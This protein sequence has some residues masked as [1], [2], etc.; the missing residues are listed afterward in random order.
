MAASYYQRKLVE[1]PADGD[2]PGLFEWLTMHCTK[3]RIGNG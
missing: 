3:E 2:V 1:H